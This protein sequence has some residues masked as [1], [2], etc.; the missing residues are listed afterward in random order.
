MRTL[1]QEDRDCTDDAVQGSEAQF[2][3]FFE[4]MDQGYILVDVIVD[5]HG[6]PVDLLYVEAN[7]AAV[8]MTGTELVGRRT[9]ELSP[10]FE[11]HWFETFDRV[12]RT[13]VGERHELSALPLDA[14]YDVYMFKVGAPGTCRV[15]AV[16]QDVTIRK[17]AEAT[18]R[19]NAIRQA[20]L[21]A[22]TDA[23]RASLDAVAIERAATRLLAEHLQA[24]R[25][26]YGEARDDGT[27]VVQSDYVR[28]GPSVAGVHSLDDYPPVGE[29]L[30]SGESFVVNDILAAPEV[31]PEVGARFASFGVGSQIAVP[32][33]RGGRLVAALM[34]NQAS[35]RV[36]TAI[37]VSLVQE[38]AARTWGEIARARSE[39]ALRDSEEQL[40][41]AH[42]ELETRVRQR[43]AEL[44]RSNAALEGE[45]RERRA[46][47]ARIQS[48]FKQLVTAQEEER[49]RIAR[50]IHDQLGQQMTA[51]RLQLEAL[52][53]RSTEGQPAMAGGVGKAQQLAHELDQSIDFL[54]WEL[55]PTLLDQLGLVNALGHLVNTWSHRFQITADY[56]APDLPDLPL[57]SE[58][59]TN[60]YRL[61]QE[62]L[63][64][65]YKHADAR[66][67]NVVLEQRDGQAR[68][69]IEDD[70]RGFDPAALAGEA[71]GG[72]GLVS[73]RER[74]AL[75][76]GELQIESAAGRGTVV[77]V[78]VP[79]P[80]AEA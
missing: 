30:R 79:L 66:Q 12:A 8:R 54:T 69:I 27:F 42:A 40:R 80:S 59:Q 68:L 9:R 11:T 2:R 46:A 71:N 55:T 72:L 5:A 64:N 4:S 43:T 77:H 41:A 1:S 78:R 74:A 60:L 21:L 70:G 65:V 19:A 57:P 67:V 58:V 37:E 45:L 31:S 39:S 24:D 29:I 47:E 44:A 52:L 75:T 32:L 10:D 33:L 20:F 17:R 63:H 14:W 13:G 25:A 48:L 7:S 23:M 35:P 56:K 28:H 73:M 50:D 34:V 51:L 36:W 61:A 49:R 62:A 26:F 18:E 53:S 38:T 76:G 3:S 16:Y 15:A 22:L 6:A